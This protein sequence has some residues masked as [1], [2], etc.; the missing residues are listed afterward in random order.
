LLLL[1]ISFL[2]FPTGLVAEHIHDRAA[3]RVAAS[4]LGTNLLLIALVV[5]GMWRYAVRRQLVR[6]DAGDDEVNTL[7]QRLTPDL[8]GYVLLIILG[9][10]LPRVAVIGYLAIALVLIIP[11]GL[12]RQGNKRKFQPK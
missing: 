3:E 1:L 9:L 2:P 12:R 10:F 8:A 11:L 5:S 4:I 7:T 6:P